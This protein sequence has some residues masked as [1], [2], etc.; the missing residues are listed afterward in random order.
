MQS[1]FE[2]F[3]IL[4]EHLNEEYGENLDSYYTNLDNYIIE[5][6]KEVFVGSQGRDA[7][8]N[9]VG[10]D[11]YTFIIP[12]FETYYDYTYQSTSGSEM[13]Q[14]GSIDRTLI[15]K[16]YLERD[17]YYMRDMYNSY[18]NGVCKYDHIENLLN[19][20]GL[21]VLFLRDSYSSPLATFFSSYCSSVDMMWTA[22]TE[23][24]VIEGVVASGEYDYIFVGLAVDSWV[25]GGAEFFMEKEEVNE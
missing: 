23:S 12:K 14:E 13:H 1:A 16:G 2:G 17:D 18:L 4:T 15:T 7:G 20:D 5:T 24:E 21:N 6:H 25:D 22:R 8:L 11:D 10:L 3:Q 9:Y 19:E